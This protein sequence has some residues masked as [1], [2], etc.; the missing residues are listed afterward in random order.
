MLGLAVAPLHAHAGQQAF[1][2]LIGRPVGEDPTRGQVVGEVL[3]V[4]LVAG[5]GVQ[6]I[7]EPRREGKLLG[8]FGVEERCHAQRV[9]RNQAGPS[10]RVE[11][12]GCV[13][14]EYARLQPAPPLPVGVR[15]EF[16]V[17]R[18][19]PPIN[20]ELPREFRPVGD[21]TTQEDAAAGVRFRSVR[22]P[23]VPRDEERAVPG[24]AACEVVHRVG[25]SVEGASPIRARGVK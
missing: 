20:A 8:P 19:L 1:N 13:L 17:A 23:R 14:A 2:R 15:H 24:D 3:L 7:D 16:G 12:D 18:A 21:A 10:P 9:V 25:P 5:R 22:R 4:E 6:Q 11:D